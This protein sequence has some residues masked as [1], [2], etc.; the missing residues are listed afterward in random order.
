MIKIETGFAVEKRSRW[1]AG[2]RPRSLMCARDRRPFRDRDPDARPEWMA[3]KATASGACANDMVWIETHHHPLPAAVEVFAALKVGVAGF[4]GPLV[5][6]CD[7][8]DIDRGIETGRV[9]LSNMRGIVR[10]GKQ[11][12]GIL[13]C[14]F[15]DIGW[16]G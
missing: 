16:W 1:A 7:S 14:A 15:R 5:S 2:E 3:A 10:S 13:R 12:R 9:S 4:P 6:F 11:P 8:T